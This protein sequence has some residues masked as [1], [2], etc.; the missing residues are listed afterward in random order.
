M[1]KQTATQFVG[2]IQFTKGSDIASSSTIAI[3]DTGNYFDITGVTTIN[4]ITAKGAGTPLVLGAASGAIVPL[5]TAGNINMPPPL[6]SAELSGDTKLFLVSDGANWNMVG[7]PIRYDSSSGGGLIDGAFRMNFDAGIL[8]GIAPPGLIVEYSSSGRTLIGAVT[9]GVAY[10]VKSAPKYTGA[11]TVTRHNYL[12]LDNPLVASSAVVTDA[13]VMRF[14][15]AAGTHKAVDGSS[16]RTT[17]GPG[18]FTVDAW[19]KVNINGTIYFLP[20]FLSKTA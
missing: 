11:F 17:W 7:G 20:A 5:T 9:D 2:G 6:V 1:S 16:S 4:T 8:I 18:P 10:G 19:V 15:A 3:P 14:D 12:Q 13:C